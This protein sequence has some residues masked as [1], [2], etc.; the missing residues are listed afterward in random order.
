[1]LSQVG[2]PEDRKRFAAPGCKRGYHLRTNPH[3]L[4]LL[5]L[6]REVLKESRT[7]DLKTMRFSMLL[8]I[9]IDMF[10]MFCGFVPF[11]VSQNAQ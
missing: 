2:L 8:V 6:G 7:K 11:C 4:H 5:H 3:A 10:W 9:H 1:M